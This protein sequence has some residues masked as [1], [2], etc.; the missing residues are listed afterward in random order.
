MSYGL[1]QVRLRYGDSSY[2]PSHGATHRLEGGLILFPG[3]ASSVRLGVTG[4]W[5][6]R[7]TAI[8]SG[9]EWEACNLIDRGC[10]FAGSPTYAGSAL[11]GTRLPHY[12]RVDL[13]LRHHWH[14][15]LA[16]RNVQ[17][18]LFGTVTNLFGRK[19]ILTYATDPKTGAAIPIEMRPLAP[20]VVGLDWRF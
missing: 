7:G 4:A 15:D 13:G 14:F 11:G 6:R 1:E 18:G 3:A 2:V 17:V 12:L 9:F 19:N 10:E 8:A 5:G 20:L 16:G